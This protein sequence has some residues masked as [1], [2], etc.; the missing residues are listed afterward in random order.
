ML[1]LPLFI[2]L[3]FLLKSNG[4]F[5]QNITSLKAENHHNVGDIDFDK[6]I[7]DPN[8][9]TCLDREIP[10]YYNANGGYKGGRRQLLKLAE[11]Q[12]QKVSY[13]NNPVKDGFITIRFIVNCKG[14]TGR[15]RVLQINQDYKPAQFNPKQVEALLDFTKSLSDWKIMQVED[16]I[17]DYYYYLTFVIKDGKTID[18][19]P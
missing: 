9:T 6:K 8:F 2:L 3:F 12:L 7:D 19:L 10:Q 13:A 4:T 5:G 17:Y 14:K 1:R 18:I 11:K 15:F 16:D